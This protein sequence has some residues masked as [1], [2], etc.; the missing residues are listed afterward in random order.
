MSKKI[1]DLSK[2][3]SCPKGTRKNKKTGEC[4]SDDVLLKSDS[5][6]FS[7]ILPN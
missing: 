6:E 7:L 3:K 5:S 2:K 4:L 1:S